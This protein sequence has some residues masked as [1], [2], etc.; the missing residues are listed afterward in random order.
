M[1]ARQ[2]K[3]QD[4]KPAAK[5]AVST[6]DTK[7]EAVTTETTEAVKAAPAKQEAVEKKAAAKKTVAKKETTTKADTD[8]NVTSN[9]ESKVAEKPA[10]KKTVKKEAATPFI[11]VQ[12]D[13]HESTVESIVERITAEYVSEGHRASSIKDLKIYL[14]PEDALAYYVINE[15]VAGSVSLF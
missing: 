15:K 3:K 5:T 6:T 12:Y 11:A 13:G 4:N 9:A 1:N 14:K 2:A 10:E 7:A 8:K